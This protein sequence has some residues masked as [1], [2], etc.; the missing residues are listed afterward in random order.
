MKHLE[1]SNGKIGESEERKAR[2]QAPFASGK[3]TICVKDETL[4]ETSRNSLIYCISNVYLLDQ[5]RHKCPNADS[6]PYT[7]KQ[8]ANNNNLVEVGKKPT[9][10]EERIY[11]DDKITSKTNIIPF[12]EINDLEVLWIANKKF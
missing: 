2:D 11:H 12:I 6:L 9:R 8:L 7:N 4:D 10:Y 1:W 5:Q 3:T